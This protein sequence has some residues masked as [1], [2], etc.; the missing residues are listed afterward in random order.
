MHPASAARGGS[1]ALAAALVAGFSVHAQAADSSPD[2]SY[3]VTTATGLYETRPAGATVLT[4]TPYYVE[5]TLPFTFA[6]FGV[7]FDEITVTSRG[8][9]GFGPLGNIT[10]TNTV[11]PLPTGPSEPDGVVAPLWDDLVRVS[12]PYMWAW[13]AGT[14]PNR[15]FVIAWEDCAHLFSP[16]TRVSFQVKLHETSGRIEFAYKPDSYPTTWT[17]LDWTSGLEA[18]GQSDKRWVAPVNASNTNS[19]RPSSDFRFDPRVVR[20]TGRA[21]YDRLVP[22]AS[23][24]G[25]VPTPAPLE[26]IVLE[27]RLS[28]GT[29]VGSTVAG[30]SGDFTLSAFAGPDERLPAI[31]AVARTAACTVGADEDSPP[32]SH[33][34]ASG[35]SFAAD[36]PLG[37]VSVDVAADP[38]AEF[39]RAANIACALQ[40]ALAWASARTGEAVPACPV[41]WDPAATGGTAYRSSATGGTPEIRVAS[42]AG[43]N[44]DAWDDAILQRVYGRHVLASIA[45]PPETGYDSR[46]DAVT[47]EQNAFAEAFG[48]WL[49][50]AISG[51]S[52]VI[53]ATGADTATS[54]D[55]EDPELASQPGPAV[56]GSI[57]AAL[58]DLVDG[59]NEPRDWW[60]GSDATSGHPLV[61]AAGLV[62]PPTLERFHKQW[63]SVAGLPGL[64][65]SRLFIAHG[66]VADDALEP[67]DAADE[68]ADLGGVPMRRAGLALSLGNEDW[69]QLDLGA[70]QPG[71]LAELVFGGPIYPTVVEFG[72]V[73]AQGRS[74]VARST[75]GLGPALAATGSLAAGR[76]RV[77]VRHTS[78]NTVPDYAL[79]VT[80]SMVST[81]PP[82]RSWTVGRPYAEPIG[83]AGG[84]PPYTLAV[85][86]G[87]FPPGIWASLETLRATGTP[88][89]VGKFEFGLSFEDSALPAHVVFAAQAVEIHPEVAVDLGEFVPFPLDGTTDVARGRT[90]GTPPYS[91]ALE[92]G[93][94]P[95]GIALDASEVR[96]SGTAITPGSTRFRVGATDVAGSSDGHDATAVVCV[97]LDEEGAATA[98]LAS[99]DSAC[100][101]FVDAVLGSGLTASVRTE[102]GRPKRSLRLVAMTTDGV[103]PPA[104]IRAGNGRANASG[105]V[106]PD[107]GRTYFVVH[108]AE[109]ADTDLAFRVAVKPP[110]RFRGVV[111]D[112]GGGALSEIAF[113]ALDGAELAFVARAPRRSGVDLHFG[114]VTAP[115]GSAVPLDG[116]VTPGKGSVALATTLRGSGTWR[117]RLRAT[118]AEPADVKWKVALRQPRGVVYRED[119][120]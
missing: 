95:E 70:S 110:P 106:A 96:F 104:K 102:R 62:V 89:E 98:A 2:A 30:A 17:G 111:P 120:E 40:E 3:S 28:D 20:F 92:S 103:L 115:D 45:A 119:Q 34:L 71:L 90:G 80:A 59:A 81:S 1:L 78:G 53:D 32:W 36:A 60:E 105:V 31:H 77:Y 12:T 83:V 18:A 85:T 46:F 6:Y 47:D 74:V 25:T 42:G 69:Y 51:E 86:G 63:V 100:G 94:L 107:T 65:L 82:L 99:G 26:G 38:S 109:G 91:V 16:S 73:D 66:L 88:D 58:H 79:Q 49:R 33:L 23:G 56:A 22:T 43:G 21:E 108:A 5:V 75:D 117:V 41:A 112:L 64:A 54:V 29:V 8:Y 97:P 113:G 7:P 4:P 76:Y 37:T 44:E 101:V 118:G 61:V 87:G 72:V 116:L 55:L 14:S 10:G 19:G 11:F 84:L 50:A 52:V 68:A 27:L 15:R 9:A 13:T 48:Y 67:D 114:R 39:R 93:A 24:F 35:L 57:A